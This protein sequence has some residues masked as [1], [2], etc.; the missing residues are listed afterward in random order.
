[1]G[2][3]TAAKRGYG[4]DW[5]KLRAEVLSGEPWCREH[6]L[7]GERVAATHVDHIKGKSEGGTDERD[8]LQPLCYKCHMSKSGKEGSRGRKTEKA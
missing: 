7:R 6:R 1:M 3:E 8:N 4:T 2:L 5:K